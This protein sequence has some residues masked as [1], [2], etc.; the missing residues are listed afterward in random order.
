MGFEPIEPDQKFS[1]DIKDDL[2]NVFFFRM[3]GDEKYKKAYEIYLQTVDK[4]NK[5]GRVCLNQNALSV[6]E[7]VEKIYKAEMEKKKEPDTISYNEEDMG[8]ICKE[9]GVDPEVFKSIMDKYNDVHKQ[10]DTRSSGYHDK[11]R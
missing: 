2:R 7:E 5:K 1:D 11:I 10:I 4:I 9:F 3:H 6:L 8:V